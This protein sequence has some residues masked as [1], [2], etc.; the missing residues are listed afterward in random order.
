MAAW[1]PALLGC[2]EA[3]KHSL[4]IKCHLHFPFCCTDINA[5]T[6]FNTLRLISA[7]D[8]GLSLAAC[9]RLLRVGS[10]ESPRG[11]ASPLWTAS[12]AS[13]SFSTWISA[14]LVGCRHKPL[15]HIVETAVLTLQSITA[16]LV[17]SQKCL[18]KKPN[19]NCWAV[20][21]S[22]Y[23]YTLILHKII[24]VNSFVPINQL[25]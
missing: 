22:F 9:P 25:F 14:G 5:G 8:P 15:L 4:M 13:V 1:L 23:T 18:K 2:S 6:L 16:I 3:V 7:P 12:N 10:R 11:A 17:S 20:T 21:G 19:T 24:V